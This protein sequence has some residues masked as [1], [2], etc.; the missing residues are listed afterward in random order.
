MN[1]HCLADKQRTQHEEVYQFEK[2]QSNIQFVSLKTSLIFRNRKKNEICLE[3]TIF[4]VTNIL[5]IFS[6][7]WYGI[8]TKFKITIGI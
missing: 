8:L 7:L 4:T 6:T 3:P 1:K 5:R 2:F